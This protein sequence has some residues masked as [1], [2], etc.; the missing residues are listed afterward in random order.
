MKKFS[1]FWKLNNADYVKGMVVAVLSSVATVLYTSIQAGDMVLR[2][3]VIGMNSLCAAIGY[4]A[5]NLVTNSNNEMFKPEL[6][7][8]QSPQ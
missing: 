8:E 7:D 1:E 4:I 3:D 5:K 2:W 6:K